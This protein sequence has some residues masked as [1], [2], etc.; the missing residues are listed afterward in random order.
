MVDVV[1][2]CGVPDDHQ[3][4]GIYIFIYH[5]NDG[6]IVAVGTPNLE[7][8]MYVDHMDVNGNSASLIVTK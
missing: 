8:L 4:S 5:L 1:R 3:G 6:S 7:R 2:K